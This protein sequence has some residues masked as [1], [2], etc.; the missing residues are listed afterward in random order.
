MNKEERLN[1]TKGQRL[2]RFLE[3]KMD[4]YESSSRLSPSTNAAMAYSHALSILENMTDDEFNEI[5]YGSE[6]YI[7]GY[8]IGDGT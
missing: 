8:V 5:T 2:S 7:D 1:T 3:D 4:E 6:D